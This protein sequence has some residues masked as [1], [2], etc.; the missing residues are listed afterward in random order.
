MVLSQGIYPGR[1]AVPILAK[2][3]TKLMYKVSIQA[4]LDS[5]SCTKVP[6]LAKLDTNSFTSVPIQT[7]LDSK[8]CNIHCPKNILEICHCRNLPYYQQ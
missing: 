5:S 7:K 4:K 8:T 3:D 1:P 6:I 2:L